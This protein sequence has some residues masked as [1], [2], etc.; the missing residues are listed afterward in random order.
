MK[1]S[2][3]GTHCAIVSSVDIEF[4]NLDMHCFV[5]APVVA[6]I[7]CLFY[8]HIGTVMGAKYHIYT[9]ASSVYSGVLSPLNLIIIN[10]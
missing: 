3:C 8:Y 9:T 4:H 6:D 5:A 7:P 2:L 1:E 10:A